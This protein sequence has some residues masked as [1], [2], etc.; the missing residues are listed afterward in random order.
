MKRRKTLKCRD[1]PTEDAVAVCKICGRGVCNNCLI[2]IANNSYCRECVEAG[3]VKAPTAEVP[4]QVMPTVILSKT[5][6]YVG[7][8]GSILS[9]IMAILLLIFSG[10][11]FLTL[12]GVSSYYSGYAAYAY[13]IGVIGISSILDIILAIALILAGIGYL[14]MKRNYG[15]GTGT[16]GFA[17]SIVA[18]VFLLISAAFGIIA[19][20]YP[21]SYYYYYTN[22]W[23]VLWVIAMF[24]TYIMFGI[25]QVLWGAAHITTRKHTGYSGLAIATGIMLIIAGAFTMTIF[26]TSIGWIL[27]FIS[28]IMATVTFM[29]WRIEQ[30]ST[31]TP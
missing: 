22:P 3:R 23:L 21:Y 4:A 8:A 9:T 18:C 26:L 24:L 5:P 20:S 2:T 17:F 28:E 12:F 19:A 15:S 10:F 27:F 7:A 6:F 29:A 1:H 16:A 31:Q 11:G 13:V 30:P 14:G 25:M